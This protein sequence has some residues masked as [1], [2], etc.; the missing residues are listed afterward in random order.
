MDS[1]WYG[2]WFLVGTL[3]W[4]SWVKP[5]LRPVWIGGTNLG[6]GMDWYLVPFLS[7][8]LDLVH[9][10]KMPCCLLVVSDTTE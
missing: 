6:V 9:G 5:G 3:I 8:V 10:M 1:V 4:I 7:L 2:Y